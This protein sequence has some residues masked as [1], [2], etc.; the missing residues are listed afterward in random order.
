M[1]CSISRYDVSQSKSGT[2]HLSTHGVLGVTVPGEQPGGEEVLV[3]CAM[4]DILQQYGTR[5]KLEHT[6]KS[7]KYRNEREGIS[8]TDPV[9]SCEHKAWVHCA[10]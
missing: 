2:A 3:I 10:P 8:V 6:F 7:L 1:I 4:I 5:K 9:R